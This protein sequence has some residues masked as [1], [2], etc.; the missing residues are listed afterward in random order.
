MTDA[1][2]QTD[3]AASQ[4]PDCVTEVQKGNTILT[5]SGFFKQDTA[6]TAVDKMEKVLGGIIERI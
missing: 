5:V 3:N 1:P 4:I 6:E 2:L